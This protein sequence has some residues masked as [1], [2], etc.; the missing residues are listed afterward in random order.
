MANIVGLMTNSEK[1]AYLR[2]LSGQGDRDDA[3][4]LAR[5]IDWY[6]NS[7]DVPDSAEQAF[8]EVCA[9]HALTGE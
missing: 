5:F 8:D 1:G 3:R 4:Q 7:G 2:C 9:R 6:E